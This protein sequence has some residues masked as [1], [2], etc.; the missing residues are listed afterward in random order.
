MPLAKTSTW[1][2]FGTLKSATGNLSAGVG[3]GD[4][5]FGARCELS[6]V[7]GAPCIHDGGGFAGAA[8]AG[9]AGADGAVVEGACCAA[10]GQAN[11]PAAIPASST[12]RSLA[13]PDVIARPP[14]SAW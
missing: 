6:A 2:F 7:V 10:A 1:K 14:Q 9:A 8:A 3:N 5:T 12:P 11:A 13:K 4:A